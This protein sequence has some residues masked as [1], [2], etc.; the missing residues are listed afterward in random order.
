MTTEA[1]LKPLGRRILD[2]CTK[3]FGDKTNCLTRNKFVVYYF[4]PNK[5]T[6]ATEITVYTKN[7]EPIF[8][9]S[10]DDNGTVFTTEYC[11]APRIRTVKAEFKQQ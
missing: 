9:Y 3:L 1:R 11:T 6:S 10:D 4:P 7:L 8:A 2:H 5:H